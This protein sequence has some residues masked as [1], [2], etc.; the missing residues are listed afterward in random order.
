MT[1]FNKFELKIIE[2][3]ENEELIDCLRLLRKAVDSIWSS[4]KRI[5][6]YYTDHGLEHSL[7]LVKSAVKLFDY[8]TGKKL[9]DEELFLLLSGI[10][11]HDIGMQFDIKKLIKENK[12]KEILDIG[13]SFGLKFDIEFE[14]IIKQEEEKGGSSFQYSSEEQKEIRAK[15]HLLT[16]TWI[17]YIINNPDSTFFYKASDQI[18]EILID[19]LITV[20]MYHSKLDIWRCKEKSEDNPDIRLRLI[21]ALIRLVDELD[22]TSSRINLDTVRLFAFPESNLIYWWIHSKTDIK[23]VKNSVRLRVYLHPD[24]YKKYSG[25]LN[26]VFLDEFKRKNESLFEVLTNNGF[27]LCLSSE[28]GVKR[29]QNAK[30][31][32]KEIK[33]ILD[34]EIEKLKNGVQNTFSNDPKTPNINLS[35]GDI[36]NQFERVTSNLYQNKGNLNLN[37]FEDLIIDIP[38]K[39]NLCYER[40]YNVKKIL[41]LFKNYSF[42]SIFGSSGE[43]KTQLAIMI[44]NSLNCRGWL[45]LRNLDSDSAKYRLIKFI[46]ILAKETKTQIYNF[47]ELCKKACKHIGKKN[48]IVIDDLPNLLGNSDFSEYFIQFINECITNDIIVLTTTYH[49]LPQKVKDVVSNNLAIEFKAPRFNEDEIMGLFKLF[50]GTSKLLTPKFL[51]SIKAFTFGHPSIIVA[52]AKYFKSEKWDYKEELLREVFSL[53]FVKELKHETL[54]EITEKISDENSLELLYRLSLCTLPFN[55]DLIRRMGIINPQIKHPLKAILKFDGLWIQRDSEENFILSPLVH[56]IGQ[57]D[58]TSNCKKECH[59][60][61]AEWILSKKTVGST[62]ALYVI[63]QFILAEEY[64]KAG[65]FLLNVLFEIN[66][67]AHMADY[68]E[69]LLFGWEKEITDKMNLSIRIAIRGFQISIGKKANKNIDYFVK[70][71]D[72]LVE[73][74]PIEEKYIFSML[75]AFSLNIEFLLEEHP[76]LSVSIL[77]KYFAFERASYSD[78]QLLELMHS[79]PIKIEKIIWIGVWHIKENDILE[80]WLELINDLDENQLKEICS[81]YYM[82]ENAVIKITNDI[83]IP[84]HNKP[85]ESRNW[86]LVLERLLLL[87]EK[88][89]EIGL[90]LLWAYTVFSRTVIFGEYLFDIEKCV[91]IGKQAIGEAS[92]DSHVNFVLYEAIGRQYYL[93]N[94]YDNAYEW[95]TKAL[96]FVSNSYYSNASRTAIR[97]SE[98]LAKINPE[99]IEEPVKYCKLAVEYAKYE[100]VD[101]IDKENEQELDMEKSYFPYELVRALGELMISQ[102][103]ANDLKNAFLSAEQA[104]SILMNHKFRDNMWKEIFVLIGN[105]ITY[106]NREYKSND[107]LHKT[108]DGQDCMVP[109]RGMFIYSNPK[110]LDYYN[111]EKFNLSYANLSFFALTA[112]RF[113]RAEYWAEFIV[114]QIKNNSFTIPL[115]AVIEILLPKMIRNKRYIESLD[116]LIQESTKTMDWYYRFVKKANY[117]KLLEVNDIAVD[118]A[119]RDWIYSLSLNFCLI[120]LKNKD[121]FKEDLFCF[122]SVC[123]ENKI[124]RKDKEFWEQCHNIFNCFYKEIGGKELIEKCSNSLNRIPLEVKHLLLSSMPDIP[125]SVSC[126]L[127][128]EAINSIMMYFDNKSSVYGQLIIPFLEKFWSKKIINNRVALRT[129]DI[130]EKSFKKAL[131]EPLEFRAKSIFKAVLEG[132]YVPLGDELKKWLY[133]S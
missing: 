12:F 2:R 25:H 103:L 117:Q 130:V 31:L 123:K 32:P 84:E 64:D 114:D 26:S 53:G 44:A 20:C 21:A 10:Y 6:Q 69:F 81:D 120:Y 28:S 96:N 15:H 119:K 27:T 133:E 5:I 82:Y 77:K 93:L 56:N 36:Q 132:L 102:W 9:S 128:I 126:G 17:Q 43:G 1:G 109:Y 55:K 39:T 46:K 129:P 72:L 131:K 80:Y 73:S 104:F 38:P 67:L 122:L 65:S 35:L 14:K 76:K 40:T 71:L 60:N 37:L 125:L 113:D 47:S 8:N 89:R 66:S 91:Q 90:E 110:L 61:I 74:A 94:Q 99:N 97:I 29:K 62:N 88:A 116:L 105:N 107:T 41:E 111:E 75:S 54:K 18:P 34:K 57:D 83:W 95:F 11:L 58:I 16:A 78:S 22:V 33:A 42:V 23:F 50:G 87:G 127:Q 45:R 92:G 51:S 115:F 24:D 19:D 98:C 86:N 4:E 108:M 3:I 30:R 68:Q 100:V 85:K 49:R 101:S 7:R 112:K 63:T 13:E 79:S 124:N 118:R 52:L 70:D 59:I 121:K 48:I 106:I